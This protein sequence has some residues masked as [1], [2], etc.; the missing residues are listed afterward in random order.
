MNKIDSAT[1]L[2]VSETE[3]KIL[4]L[5]V[6]GASSKSIAAQLGYKDGTTRVYLHSLYKR[7]GVNN[8]TSAV[9][10]YLASQRKPDPSEGR[11]VDASVETFGDRSVRLD[12]LSSLGIMEVFLG[13]HGRMW[14][15]MMRLQE[16]SVDSK[17]IAELRDRSR[18]LWNG[19]VG[20][21]F[22]QS[23]R[24]YDQEG[25]AKLFLASPSDAVVLAMSLLLGGFTARADKATASLKIKRGGSIGITQDE[26]IALNAVGDLIE[27]AAGEEGLA[28]L[29]RLADRNLQRPVFRHLLIVSLFHIYKLRKDSVRAAATGNAVWAEAEA[30]R[31]HLQS[32]G[33]GTFPAEVK[34]P[35]PPRLA[36]SVL[37]DYLAKIAD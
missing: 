11:A 25:I 22:A 34:L 23:A 35:A 36:K 9:T 5:L 32:M 33:D 18:L 6:T 31:N 20:G 7:I 4:E 1:T 28:A 14:D 24:Y 21:D 27:G 37:S 26:K 17:S 19:L 29:H 16:E 2:Q 15:T 30:A 13:P 10:W 3:Q 12:L 8:K